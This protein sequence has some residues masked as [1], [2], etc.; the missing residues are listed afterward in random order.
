MSAVVTEPMRHFAPDWAIVA[1]PNV[2][3]GVTVYASSELDS[4][5]L[6]ARV[7]FAR[8]ATGD[9]AQ[10]STTAP[11]F[12]LTASMRSVVV[13][14]GPDYPSAVAELFAKWRPPEPDENVVV[15]E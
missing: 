6:M 8:V 4:A 10:T 2:D 11:I 1:C 7:R 3:G 9:A 13:A 15:V 5:K 14:D 12:E